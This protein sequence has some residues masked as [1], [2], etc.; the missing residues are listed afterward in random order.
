MWY[1]SHNI[2]F[3]DPNID[4]E[5]TDGDGFSNHDEFFA[6]TDP[7]DPN[8]HPSY[9]GQLRI[10][11]FQQQPFHIKFTNHEMLGGKPVFLLELKD[12]PSENQPGLVRS[13]DPLGVEGYIVGAFKEIHV[14]EKMGGPHE[15]SV[16]KSTLELLKPDIGFKITL[17]FQEEMLAPDITAIFN[18]LMPKERG[19][20]EPVAVGKVFNISNEPDITYTL[21]SVNKDDAGNLLTAT[22]RDEKTKKMIEVPKL[23]DGEWDWVPPSPQ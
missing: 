1:K 8:S 2:D 5:D 11:D 17:V 3:K 21:I 14:M 16:D 7:T 23:K 15:V 4:H 10:K 18:V 6:K 22:I 13:G 12:V 20:D 9:L 19:N